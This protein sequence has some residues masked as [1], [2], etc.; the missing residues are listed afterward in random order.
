MDMLLQHARGCGW[1]NLIYALSCAA[2]KGQVALVQQLLEQGFGSKA[3]RGMAL[4]E[5]ARHGQVAIME[6]LQGVGAV[7]ADAR[8]GRPL[9]KAAGGGR[10]AAAKPL[11]EKGASVHAGPDAALEAA[12]GGGHLAVVQLLLGCW[13]FQRGSDRAAAAWDE[14]ERC[15]WHAEERLSMAAVAWLGLHALQSGRRT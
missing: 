3:S 10:G 13:G 8:E 11:L 9:K 14:E 4:E 2:S 1:M 6:L 15:N 12:A 7:G 5:A